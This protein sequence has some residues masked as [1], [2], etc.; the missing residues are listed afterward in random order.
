[1]MMSDR[2][3]IVVVG[4]G[5]AGSSIARQLSRMLD[6]TKHNLILISTRNYM[7]HYPSIIRT[8]VGTGVNEDVPFIPLDN[9][10]DGG[11]GTLM[12]GKV[13]SIA[14]EGPHGGHLTLEDGMVISWSVL[15]LA[16]GTIWEGPVAFPDPKDECMDHLREWKRKFQAARNIAIAGAGAVGVELATELKYR[17]PDKDIT[18]VHSQE[19]PM[20]DYYPEKWRK[21]LDRRIRKQ[22]IKLIVNDFLDDLTIDNHTV[23]T[24]N[25]ETLIA[26]LVVSHQKRKKMTTTTMFNSIRYRAGVVK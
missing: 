22:G 18:I 14:D 19:L 1:M 12:I 25:G 4:A 7:I 8:L 23:T 20:N 6:H 16:P 11:R 10:F 5:G 2:E 3:N 17:F 24:R 9:L 21:V 15:V 26:D 13:I